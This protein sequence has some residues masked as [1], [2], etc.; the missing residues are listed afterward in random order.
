MKTIT[1][2]LFLILTGITEA[3]SSDIV[4]SKKINSPLRTKIENDLK[5]I[6]NFKYNNNPESETLKVMGLEQFNAQTTS[7]WL[8]DRVHYIIEEKAFN[9]FN[10]FFKRVITTEEKNVQYPE[11]DILPY[12]NSTNLFDNFIDQN[13]NQQSNNANT[14]YTVMANIGSALYIS[15][16]QKE[17]V[18]GLKI[19]RGFL[20]PSIK[21]KIDSP[22]SGI[23]QIGEG[24][25]APELLLNSENVNALSN[26]IFRIGTYFHEAR[27]S[28]GH[29]SSLGFTHVDCPVGHDYEG[30]PAC[31]ENLNG[32][33]TVGTLMIK[34]MSKTCDV[35][36][37]SESDKEQLR[38]LILDNASRILTTTHKNEESSFWDDRPEKLHQ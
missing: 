37:C 8:G 25:F 11:S 21:V 30:V 27:H 15:G 32:P 16:K 6:E 2:A 12:S 1:L 34:E 18:Y 14:K 24:L 38:L 13:N 19:S 20:R 7:K 23:L 33:Y 17:E 36:T 22:R 10:L 28:D 4:L 26:I 3:Q 35:D 29:G 31:D 5:L 9:F